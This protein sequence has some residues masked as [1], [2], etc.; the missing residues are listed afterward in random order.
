MEHDIVLSDEVDELRV[1]ALPPFVPALR[2]Q[3]LGIG[4]I[5]NRSIEPH[6]EYLALGTFHRHRNA[7]VQV[8]G[9]GTR[10]ET[11]VN[12]ALALAID[13]A[14]PLLVVLQNP[15]AQPFLILIQ[16]E[17]PVGSLFLHRLRSAELGLRI[18]EFFRAEG[19]AAFLALVAI[20][21]LSSAFRA[22]SDYV[23]VSEES[24]CLRVVVLL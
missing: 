21:S 22:G 20:G 11:A 17:I 16:R 24:L 19:A 18:D 12:P 3:F 9:Y 6:V 5:A 14:P 2:E 15:H 4:N 7:P 13:I 23:P 10:L 8:A 1:P